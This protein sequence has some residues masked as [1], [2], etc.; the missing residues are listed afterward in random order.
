[1]D[2]YVQDSDPHGS[3]AWEE[4][5]RGTLTLQIGKVSVT[6]VK[7]HDEG[8]TPRKWCSGN[9]AVSCDASCCHRGPLQTVPAMLNSSLGPLPMSP[10]T[11]HPL[12]LA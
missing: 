6:S 2:H 4:G 5:S 11:H 10:S 12:S 9:L 3:P 8:H 7:G 1:M